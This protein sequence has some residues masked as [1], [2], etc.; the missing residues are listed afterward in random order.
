MKD[1]LGKVK[2]DSFDSNRL[3]ADN[4]KKRFSLK[5]RGIKRKYLLS[6]TDMIALIGWIKSIVAVMTTE[7]ICRLFPDMYIMNKLMGIDL[8]GANATSQALFIFNSAWP[9]LSRTGA[10]FSD[11]E[12]F[13]GVEG[14]KPRGLGSLLNRHEQHVSNKGKASKP[15]AII[16]KWRVVDGPVRH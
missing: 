16:S 15:W 13:W 9:C 14:L 2:S 3:K 12:C 6:W 10:V 7:K 8:A 1:S 5:K 11:L 4:R